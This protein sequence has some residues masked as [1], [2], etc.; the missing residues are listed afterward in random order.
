MPSFAESFSLAY[1]LHV[2]GTYF[3]G[4][5]MLAHVGAGGSEALKE[6]CTG[7]LENLGQQGPATRLHVR[8]VSRVLEGNGLQA[9]AQPTTPDQYPEWVD[10]VTESFYPLIE[11]DEAAMKGYSSGWFL[12]AYVENANLAAFALMLKDEDD[13]NEMV[14][15]HLADVGAELHSASEGFAAAAAA[16]G[17]DE[18]V[19]ALF[20]DAANQIQGGPSVNDSEQEALDIA[21]DFQEVLYELGVAVEK[22]DGV[23]NIA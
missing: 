16:E 14:Q 19:R 12:G 5:A 17:L 10:A 20:E 1:S 11:T 18:Q 22:L 9:P 3:D 6:V 4:A 8:R 13:E 21:D 7:Q 2:V 23:L 15:S